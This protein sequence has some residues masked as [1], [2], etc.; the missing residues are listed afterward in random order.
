MA[1]GAG[2]LSA[3]EPGRLF[4]AAAEGCVAGTHPASRIYLL[5]RV[6]RFGGRFVGVPPSPVAAFGSGYRERQSLHTF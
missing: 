2:A 5:H 1:H 4:V 3:I 6:V